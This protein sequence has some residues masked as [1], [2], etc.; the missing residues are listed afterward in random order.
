MV[1]DIAGMISIWNHELFSADYKESSC[2]VWG[3]FS[4][5]GTIDIVFFIIIIA[6]N[7]KIIKKRLK[8]NY[9]HLENC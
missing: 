2:M 8:H 6:N 9:L 7:L 1:G 4:F 3:E 5:N